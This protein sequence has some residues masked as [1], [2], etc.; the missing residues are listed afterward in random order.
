MQGLGKRCDMSE[1]QVQRWFRHREAERRSSVS[2][3]DK[4]KETGWDKGRGRVRIYIVHQVTV[5][6]G[7]GLRS[8]WAFLRMD[9]GRCGM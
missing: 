1:R 8:I 9:Y 3:L 5:I 6:S 4:F 2:P 7:G